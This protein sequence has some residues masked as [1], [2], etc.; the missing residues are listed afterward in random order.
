MFSRR[1]YY[2]L[3]NT[4]FAK[5]KKV[6]NFTQIHF[7]CYKSLSRRKLDI[8]TAANATGYSVVDHFINSKNLDFPHS[9]NS[10]IKLTGDQSK[11][12]INCMDWGLDG[13]AQSDYKAGKWSHY[14]IEFEN[15]LISFLY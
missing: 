8:A 12:S 5:L 14:N 2:V 1:E 13:P 6:M 15:R 7:K 11:L 9:C 10:F 4:A 3:N